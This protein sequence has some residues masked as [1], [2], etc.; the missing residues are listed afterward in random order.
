[1]TEDNGQPPFDAEPTPPV[2]PQKRRPGRPHTAGL[3]F[4]NPPNLPK[5]RTRGL[6]VQEAIFV[7][8][9]MIDFNAAAA[10]RRCGFSPDRPE[11]ARESGHQLLKR[12]RVAA[13]LQDALTERLKRIE[14]QGDAV[15]KELAALAFADVRAIAS[16]TDDKVTLRPSADL[17]DRDAAA[18]AEVSQGKD[19]TVRVRMHD[20]TGP[21]SLLMRH[22]NLLPTTKIRGPGVDVEVHGD[23]VVIYLPDNGRDPQL[24]ALPVN[25][26]V[27]PTGR[28]IE[29]VPDDDDG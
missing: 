16:W 3:K 8:E 25:G 29:E 28:V 23:G 24:A 27:I 17:N 18:I 9:Y 12:P 7:R 5:V 20:K 21:L 2:P 15:V 11:H 22:L 26:H 4:R 13:A 1:M 10:A 6:T 14:L 19:G